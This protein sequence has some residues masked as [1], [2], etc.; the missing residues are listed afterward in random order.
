MQQQQDIDE[1]KSVQES[2][3]VTDLEAQQRRRRGKDEA[4]KVL[5]NA[6]NQ[7]PI[8]ETEEQAV[9]RK[10]DWRVMPMLLITT[11]LQYAD[12]SS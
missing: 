1:K 2:V 12:K 9:L 7:A 5:A 8:T 11:G 3:A 6:D 4:T 10:I